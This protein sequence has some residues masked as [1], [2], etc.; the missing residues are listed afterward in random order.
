MSKKVLLIE[1]SPGLVKTL[2]DLLTTEGYEVRSA[3]TGEE[4]RK[5]ACEELFDVVVLDILLPG[6]SG[7]DVCRQV[8]EEGV[9]TPILMLTARGEI[10]DKVKGLKLGADD[11]LTKPFEPPELLARLEALLRRTS[12]SAPSGLVRF[13][14]VVVDFRATEVTRK[15]KPVELAAREFQLLRYFIENPGATL[16]REQ[17]L[18][19]VWGYRV[20]IFTRTLDV[21]VQVLRHKL[22]ENPR[23]PEHF[24]TVRGLGYKFIA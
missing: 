17:L 4:G 7:F 24:V 8:R 22:E 20:P 3:L 19:D 21:H 12:S 5:H 18:R 1:D 6:I 10:E 2:C 16:S 15:G 9:R 23:N 14:S 11:Y 13:G